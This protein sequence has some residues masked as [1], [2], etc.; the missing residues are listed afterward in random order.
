[1]PCITEAEQTK[2]LRKI[3]LNAFEVHNQDQLSVRLVYWW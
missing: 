2:Q 1:M 3:A